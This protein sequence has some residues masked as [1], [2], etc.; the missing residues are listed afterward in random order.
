MPEAEAKDLRTGRAGSEGHTVINS[1]V[2]VPR[3]GAVMSK[4]KKR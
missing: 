4:D 2:R 1:G 3:S